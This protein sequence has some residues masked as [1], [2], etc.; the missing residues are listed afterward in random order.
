MGGRIADGVLAGVN[1]SSDVPP[2]IG[3]WSFL[4]LRSL[5]AEPASLVV[6]ERRA[7]EGRVPE[8]DEGV[9]LGVRLERRVIRLFLPT[10]CTSKG[11][12]LVLMLYTWT[13]L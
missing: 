5:I 4:S 11:P 7:Y 2:R 12:R 3:V 6:E 9:T 13:D 1:G 10:A 8:D